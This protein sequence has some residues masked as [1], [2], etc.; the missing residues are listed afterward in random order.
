MRRAVAC[1]L[2][3]VIFAACASAPTLPAKAGPEEV[4]FYNPDAG[5]TPPAGYETISEV[6]VEV[7]PGTQPSEIHMALRAEAARLGADAIIMRSIRSNA[8]GQVGIDM[9]RPE[10]LIGLAFAIYWPGG[11]PAG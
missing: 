11:K 2:G 10:K 5:T 1:V 6:R 7:D 8:E 9:N 4:D 3:V